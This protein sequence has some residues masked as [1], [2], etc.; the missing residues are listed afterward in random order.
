MMF[1]N[2]THFFFGQGEALFGMLHRPPDGVRNR[3]A[4]IWCHPFGNER[5]NA[6]RLSF[7]WARTMS[8]VGYTVLRFDY[9]GTGE[10]EGI[11][12]DASVDGHVK[13][14][15][16]AVDELERRTG[17]LISGLGGLRLGA[18]IA[19]A[20]ASRL[21]Q[22]VDLLMWEPI[23][24][25][26]VYRDQLLRV[27]MANEMT[28]T[29]LAPRTRAQYKE[30][31]MAGKTVSV[32]GFDLGKGMYDSLEMIDLNAQIASGGGRVCVVQ[33][34]P[35][36]GRPTR[37]AIQKLVDACSSK[38]EIVHTLVA[39]PP[40]WSRIKT[41]HWRPPALFNQSLT[42]LADGQN[43]GTASV[44][45]PACF[46][47]TSRITKHGESERPIEFKIEGVPVRGVYHLPESVGSEV[48][49][50]V[51]LPAGETCRS[52]VFYVPL[53]RALAEE[54]W[55]VLRLD[56]RCVGDS[57]G[58]FGVPTL[59]EVHCKI[60]DGAMLPDTIA[61]MDYLD[62]AYGKG[63]Y[64]LSG[65]CGGAITD[66]FAG[67]TDERVV[68]ILPLELRFHYPPIPKQ[69]ASGNAEYL[70]LTQRALESRLAFAI[71]PVRRVYRFA[72]G[73]A[74]SIVPQLLCAFKS[75][76]A[77][78]GEFEQRIIE[79]LGQDAITPM[80]V[81][82]SK[83]I[84]RGIPVF[85]LFADTEEPRHLEVVLGDL[86]QGRRD[87]PRQFIFD[88]ISGADHNFVRPG[89]TVELTR[90]VLEWLNDPARPWQC[91]SDA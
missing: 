13:D 32:D 79:K 14:T 10:S 39:A 49:R 20:A 37:P 51:M 84:G 50:I 18:D 28:A 76:S 27:A 53:A 45:K 2:D 26:S 62:E 90:R 85:C 87:K 42:W 31:L 19:A 71:M 58:E 82:L 30:D 1:E 91:P 23:I 29:G 80:L 68:G 56:A 8:E 24:A 88:V 54:G 22:R 12:T 72:K 64:V 55:P 60:A 69:P 83:A 46:D 11:F 74:K 59:A 5:S 52:A 70:S 61:A 65:L 34:D 89:Y 33:I 38:R 57:D 43:A 40:A 63:A 4:W 86:L 3:G 9:R 44:E 48:P 35:V 47:L 81:A 16:E 73:R 77:K 78:S 75:N 41:W 36:T 6:H 7:E 66:A 17:M 15:L 67:A 25:G 21:E